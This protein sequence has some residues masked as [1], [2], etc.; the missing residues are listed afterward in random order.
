M[1]TINFTKINFSLS[2]LLHMIA[3]VELMH[4]TIYTCKEIKFPRVPEENSL[5]IPQTFPSDQEIQQTIE[6]ARN[7]ALK[8][9]VQFGITLTADD[10][11]HADVSQMRSQSVEI[12]FEDD[13]ME[14][15]D[16][17]LN[18]RQILGEGTS[19]EEISPFL[20]YIDPD[21]ITRK[22]RK[23]TFIWEHIEEKDKLSSR[24]SSDRLK[25]VQGSSRSL[26]GSDARP[27]AKRQ[28][29]SSS[30]S[31]SEQVESISEVD[32]VK[33]DD[34]MVGDW[35]IFELR[36]E[37]ITPSLR[38]EVAKQNGHLI[39]LITGFRYKDENNRKL[40]YKSNIVSLLSENR[41]RKRILVLAIW[42]GCNE[43]GIFNQIEGTLSVGIESYKRTMKM[44]NIKKES[45]SVNYVLP[46]QYSEL[47]KLHAITE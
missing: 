11:A 1:G 39:G 17:E 47:E 9:A 36:R 32:L 16:D 2:E 5:E 25:R 28:K 27:S 30:T 38:D 46:F 43:N 34:I 24:L 8:D 31:S 29:T 45:G 35:S 40:Q 42:Y 14:S 37:T 10:I 13:E 21:G 23:S 18:D 20:F 3:R 26:I 41:E 12:S 4:K 22:V 19:G 15:S 44:P 7:D 33:L 6:N